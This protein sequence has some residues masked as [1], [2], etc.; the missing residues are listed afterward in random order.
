M[1]AKQSSFIDENDYITMASAIAHFMG[2]IKGSISIYWGN[3]LLYSRFILEYEIENAW[4]K[5][6]FWKDVMIF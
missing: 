5:S 4:I 6:N 1:A 2:Y 3:N